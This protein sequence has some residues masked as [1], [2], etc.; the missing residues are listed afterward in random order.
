[1]RYVLVC[2]HRV[3]FL[4]LFFHPD[5][6]SVVL[7]N[8]GNRCD[9]DVPLSI[10]YC[11]Q[12]YRHVRRSLPRCIFWLTVVDVVLAHLRIYKQMSSGSG[13]QGDQRC[14]ASHESDGGSR[15]HCL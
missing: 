5:V 15:A 14:I 4:L 2:H 6:P 1:M 12:V 9:S 13:Y 3:T 7:D 8:D 10:K 11:L